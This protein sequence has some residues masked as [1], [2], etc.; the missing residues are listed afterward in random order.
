MIKPVD[1]LVFA[2]ACAAG[3]GFVAGKLDVDEMLRAHIERQQ[4]RMAKLSAVAMLDE[5]ESRKLVAI[6]KDA[7]VA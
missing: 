2:L 7:P 3:A 5:F 4:I 1:V 6:P